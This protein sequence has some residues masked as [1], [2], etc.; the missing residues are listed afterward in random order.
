MTEITILAPGY[1]RREKSLIYASPNTVLLREHGLII[2]VD[3]GSNATLLLEGLKRE[4]LTIDDI[5]F[6]FLTHHHL[7][8]VLNIRLFPGIDIYDGDTK[9]KGD[10]ISEYK[11]LIPGTSIQVIPTPGHTLEHWS[12]LVRNEEGITAVAGDTIWWWEDEEVETEPTTILR[13]PDMYAYN[14]DELRK[15]RQTLL[16]FAD[17]IIPGHGKPFS[18]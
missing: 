7:D 10:M 6:I 9:N 5:N 12:L 3:P 16:D 1:A 4:S 14:Q 17:I 11:G 15:S 13:H 8:H 2:L 18:V